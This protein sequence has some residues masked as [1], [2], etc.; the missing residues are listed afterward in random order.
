MLARCPSCRQTFSTDRTG[1]Q[2]CPHCQKPLI[3]P[4]AAA[5]PAQPPASQPAPPPPADGFESAPGDEP[6]TPWERRQ[7]L[8]AFA[9]W[10]QTVWMSLFEPARLFAQARL[11][12]GRDQLWFALLTGSVASILSQL[13]GRLLPKASADQV[14]KSMDDLR[15]IGLTLPSWSKRLIDAS[16]ESDSLGWALVIAAFAPVM[17]FILIYLNA[18]ITHASALL[19]GNA[20]R[21]FAASFAA[22]TYG[23]TPL[24]LLVVPVCGSVAALVWCAVLIGVGMK[25]THRI[26]TN[27]AA[28]TVLAPYVLLCCGGCLLIVTVAALFGRS[29]GGMP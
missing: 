17:M 21:G 15:N 24:V 11:D 25:Y 9:A 3:V 18:G 12:K 28:V 29:M 1:Q 4:D 23:L 13:I 6:G 5:P 27:K 26:T 22:A 19:L 10:K 20:R 8:G 7:T 14:A 16:T 2:T